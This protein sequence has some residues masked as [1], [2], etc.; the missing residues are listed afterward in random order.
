MISSRSNVFKSWEFQN[1]NHEMLKWSIA[2]PSSPYA[3]SGRGRWSCVHAEHNRPPTGRWCCKP[4]WH[5]RVPECSYVETRVL[6]RLV[7]AHRVYSIP[8]SAGIRCAMLHIVANAPQ[9]KECSEEE[10]LLVIMFLELSKLGN[11]WE[12][13][14][15]SFRLPISL[16]S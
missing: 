7:S 13:S 15:F 8:V 16:K 12:N 9:L 10:R 3:W 1:F 2:S 11:I 5:K 6:G 4:N 14:S